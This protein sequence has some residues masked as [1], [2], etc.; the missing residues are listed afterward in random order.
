[1]RDRREREENERRTERMCREISERGCV[2]E[3]C[4]G[5]EG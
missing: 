1:M 2:C 4:D 3:E 5:G